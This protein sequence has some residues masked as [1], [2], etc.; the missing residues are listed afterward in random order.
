[1][2]FLMFPRTFP[3]VSFVLGLWQELFFHFRLLGMCD[4]IEQQY[5]ENKM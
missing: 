4:Q 2:L 5:F 3:G 1:M